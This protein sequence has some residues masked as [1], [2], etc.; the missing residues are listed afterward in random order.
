MNYLLIFIKKSKIIIMIHKVYLSLGSNLGNKT[1]NLETAKYEITLQIGKIVK[2]GNL[3]ETEPW[4]F[5]NEHWF[6][7]TVIEI[8]TKLNEIETL[9]KCLLIEKKMGRVRNTINNTY[10]ARIID[11]DILF[12][13]NQIINSPELSIPHPH[14]QDRNFVLFP[15]ADIAAEFIHPKLNKSIKNLLKECKDTTQIKK[16]NT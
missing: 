10:T 11:I 6:L 12:F 16:L 8:E 13:D 5:E 14:I 15:L 4:G 3:Y 7:N 1:E 9:K 2:T